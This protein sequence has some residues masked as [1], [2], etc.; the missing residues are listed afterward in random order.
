MHIHICVCMCAR[1]IVETLII[2]LWATRKSPATTTNAN[3]AIQNNTYKQGKRDREMERGK[4]QINYIHTHIH[5]QTVVRCA[6][7]WY[8][9]PTG[10]S[11]SRK[12]CRLPTWLPDCLTTA[13]PTM[14]QSDAVTLDFDWVCA[15]WYWEGARRVSACLEGV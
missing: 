13:L 8:L 12:C 6:A 15:R 11:E 1:Q 14:P 10:K 7:T 5:A 4:K 2:L 9:W 3:T